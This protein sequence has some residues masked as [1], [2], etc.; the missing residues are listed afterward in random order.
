MRSPRGSRRPAS[1]RFH[2]E[3]LPLEQLF[4]EHELLLLRK[5]FAKMCENAGGTVRNGLTREGFRTFTGVLGLSHEL[6]DRMFHSFD[7][8]NDDTISVTEYIRGINV[9]TKGNKEQR[10]RFAFDMFDENGDGTISK[11]E[12]GEIFT[13][14]QNIFSGARGSR[15]GRSQ[16]D[17]IFEYLDRD[18][19]GTIT[20]EE[21]RRGI[22]KHPQLLTKFG[23]HDN[24]S[25]VATTTRLVDDVIAHAT[26][27]RDSILGHRSTGALDGASPA[28][29]GAMPAAAAP[30]TVPDLRD[31]TVV[32]SGEEIIPPNVKGRPV[33][34]QSRGSVESS[35]LARLVA[36]AGKTLLSGKLF[37]SAR[38]ASA[39]SVVAIDP[40]GE[41]E[42]AAAGGLSVD[43][44]AAAEEGAEVPAEHP[45]VLPVTGVVRLRSKTDWG[46]YLH[47]FGEVDWRDA[48]I[49][50]CAA[51]APPS[52]AFAEEEEEKEE[53]E[54]EEEA[55]G[56]AHAAV[57][58]LP[59]AV[60]SDS[61]GELTRGV[62]TLRIF[63]VAV[64]SSLSTVDGASTPE[65]VLR[66]EIRC[67]AHGVEGADLFVLSVEGQAR[68]R[69]ATSR[70]GQWKL[71]FDA[72]EPD[73]SSDVRAAT[74]PAVLRMGRA[75]YE[76][77]RLQPGA[78]RG[79]G[80]SLE[81]EF[82]HR[83]H[84]FSPDLLGAAPKKSSRRTSSEVRVQDRRRTT[85]PRS[86]VCLL[87]L[88]FVCS[89][90][91]HPR[92][93]FAHSFV[94]S[95]ASRSS[96][97]DER[98]RRRWRHAAEHRPGR[99][100]HGRRR[101]SGDELGDAC[102]ADVD[103]KLRRRPFPKGARA[104]LSRTPPVRQSTPRLSP[105][106]FLLFFYF[107]SCTSRLAHAPVAPTLSISRSFSLSRFLSLVLSRSPSPR[108][109]ANY[110]VVVFMKGIQYSVNRASVEGHLE[111]RGF[112]FLSKDNYDVE[113]GPD[114][115]G[116]EDMSW[117]DLAASGR[118]DGC[119]RSPH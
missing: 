28:A 75:L 87:I 64:D 78:T 36:G 39:L 94:C 26:M 22:S 54:V 109:R 5:R 93:L 76:L 77:Q 2:A 96:T 4:S 29:S 32:F 112:H 66:G 35:S 100:R 47:V 9:M 88:L 46:P 60:E 27:L 116:E 37:V 72:F 119:V 12:M 70:C 82:G 23:M 15:T 25:S 68:A 65:L 63:D 108:P 45:E 48:A 67:G 83:R 101:E 102:E 7:R 50:A 20:Y 53:T 84:Q 111:L 61:G 24:S 58:P 105:I 18:H 40:E 95:T 13:S 69:E 31:C 21:F 85:C 118:E 3:E 97:N 56:D 57:P 52:D 62:L 98:A 34:V 71:V 106:L 38:G 51:A 16:S 33:S 73:S 115:I 81:S 86:F 91:V 14:L 74:T 42:G 17:A 11:D 117:G 110:Q 55:S 1:L 89:F 8:D 114:V 104:P 30:R 19:D 44:G 99:A 43:A 79:H 103:C 6:S 59:P 92:S 107:Y 49:K 80:P 41:D 90:F 113:A 10:I